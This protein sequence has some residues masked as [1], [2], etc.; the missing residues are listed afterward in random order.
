MQ[1]AWRAGKQVLAAATLEGLDF[2]LCTGTRLGDSPR[3]GL[4]VE[5]GQLVQGNAGKGERGYIRYEGNGEGAC[6][7]Q[8]SAGQIV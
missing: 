2:L 8:R 1:I 5:R 6:G 4:V 7:H 3:D